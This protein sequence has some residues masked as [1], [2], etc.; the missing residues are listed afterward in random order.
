M[1]FLVP[2]GGFQGNLR[3]NPKHNPLTEVLTCFISVLTTENLGDTTKAFIFLAV[4]YFA[5]AF[6]TSI[7]AFKKH[8]YF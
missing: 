7:L 2:S 1:H 3:Q 5:C 4:T 6:Y 8:L